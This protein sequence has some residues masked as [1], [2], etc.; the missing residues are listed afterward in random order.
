MKKTIL[1][2]FVNSFVALVTGDD[3]QAQAEQTFRQATAGLKSHIHSYEGDTIDFETNL[4]QA[5]IEL[6]QA[7]VN[8]GKIMKDQIDRQ[9]Y[10]LILIA[11][12]N[13]AVQAEEELQLH[14]EKI[15]FLKEQLDI[16]S[17]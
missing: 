5:K 14:K 8:H 9:Q 15:E 17:K 3:A 2:S 1:T 11:A 4:A 16:I 7:R 10:V 6:E 12:R 13:K